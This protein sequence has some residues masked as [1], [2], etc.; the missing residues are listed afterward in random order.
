MDDETV[1]EDDMWS[2][3][4]QAIARILLLPFISSVLAVMLRNIVK[5]QVRC[6]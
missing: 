5:V 1:F 2:S 3:G 6:W 4:C